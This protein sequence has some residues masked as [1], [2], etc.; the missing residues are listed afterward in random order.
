MGLDNCIKFADQVIMPV[1]EALSMGWGK[2]LINATMDFSTK[3]LQL[4]V[5][6]NEFCILNAIVLTYPG[7][8]T[9]HIK[10]GTIDNF[11]VAAWG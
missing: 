9:S 6:L 8:Y 4:D 7:M 10:F 1:D 5:D 3:L 11:H 2:E